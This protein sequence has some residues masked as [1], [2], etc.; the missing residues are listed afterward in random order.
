MANEEQLLTVSEAAPLLRKTEAAFRWYLR[1]PDCPLQTRKIGRR[2]MIRRSDVEAIS[3]VHADG[4]LTDASYENG[5]RDGYRAAL[6]DM[7]KALNNI[8]K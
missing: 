4:A 7:R 3:G 1:Q 2:V 8:D 5:Y 6:A